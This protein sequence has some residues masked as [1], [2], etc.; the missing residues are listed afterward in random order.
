MR[1]NEAFGA[2]AEGGVITLQSLQK[3]SQA[4]GEAWTTR[5]LQEM[6]NEADTNHDGHID[7]SEFER[8]WKLTGV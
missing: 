3:A 8:I 4:Q 7:P 2:L 1:R 5:E 6:M